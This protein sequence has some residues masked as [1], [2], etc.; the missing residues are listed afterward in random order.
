MRPLLTLITLCAALALATPAS[1]SPIAYVAQGGFDPMPTARGIAVFD[2]ATGAKLTSID[3]PTPALDIAIDPTGT[4]AYVTT[5]AGLAVVNLDTNAVLTTIPGASGSDV[6]V[7]P[8]GARVYVADGVD[9]ITVV[10]TA[11]NTVTGTGITVGKQPRAVVVNPAG[12]LAYTGNTRMSPYSISIVD[13]TTNTQTSELFSGNLNRPENLGILPDGTKVYAANFGQSAGGTTVGIL[14]TPPSNNV[15]SANVGMSPLSVMANPSGTR[16]YVA[17]RDSKS[18]S[19]LDGPMGIPQITYSFDFSPTEIAVA[20][21]GKRAILASSQDEKVAFIDL[22]TGQ[23]YSGPTALASAAG[24]AI[25]PAQPP[26]PAFS[27]AGRV[28]GEATKFDASSSTGGPITRFDWEFGDG[29]TA[30]DGGSKVRHTYAAPG[31]YQAKL[32]V[33]NG[34]DPNAIFG[35]LNVSFG[36]HSPFCRGAR[37]DSK[38]VQI[39]IPPVA[40]A[41]VQTSKTK[42]GKSGVAGL[43]VACI[44]Q[45]DCAGTLSLKTTS[46][47]KVGKHPR[48]RIT[49]GSKRFNTI[50]AGR[51][52]TIKLKLSTTGLRLLR[53]RKTLTATATASVTNPSGGPRIRS[54]QVVLKRG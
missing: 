14:A 13:L 29:G 6:A 33:T 3:L 5:G 4:R 51:K 47:F 34:C 41:V 53:S 54:R 28:S 45:L 37:T 49:L 30:P 1:A 24:V 12:T 38:T 7:D 23:L 46:K 26:V 32:T 43:Q 16:I 15:N 48:A 8:S 21:D 10:D 17:N 42:V 44:K 36:G 27:V 2:V 22:T 19:V 18:L 25:R 11:T 35:P 31:T 39:V 9:K 20:P 50:R 52:R 40:L